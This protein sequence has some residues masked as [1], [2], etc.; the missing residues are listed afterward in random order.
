MGRRGE[1]GWGQQ[2]HKVYQF[3]QQQKSGLG[4]PAQFKIRVV[5]VK[6]FTQIK[7]FKQ[8]LPGEKRIYC[9]NSNTHIE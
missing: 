8:N 4:L 3:F 6:K 5:N 9:D 2:V 1:G 7:S